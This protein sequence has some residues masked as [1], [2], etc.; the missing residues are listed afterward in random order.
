MLGVGGAIWIGV[1][2]VAL[3]AGFAP[4]GRRAADDLVHVPAETHRRLERVV[5]VSVGATILILIAFLAYDFTVGRALAQHPQR[6]MTIDVTGH[7]WWWEVLYEDP[8]PSRQL[9]TA[10]EIHVPV[11][12]PV[13]FKLR[14]AD[15]IHSFWAPNLSGKRDLIPGYMSTIWFKADTPGVYR[16]Q[17]AEFCG[18]QHAK[19]AFYVVADPRP[20]FDAWLAAASQ[21][22]QTPTDSTLL[23]GERVFLSSGCAVCHTISGTQAFATVGPNLSHFG[24]R[25]TIAAGTLPN[26]KENLARWIFNPQMIKPGVIM[27]QVPLQPAQLSAVVAYLESLK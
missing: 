19:M 16:G 17:C 8:D 18:L 5:S 1:T 10:N 9:L 2:I 3:Y 26:T 15:V 22:H 27:P 13:Q 4:R 6:G 11:G 25:S 23:S 20:K 24:S 12:E 21:S 14:A 7:Q